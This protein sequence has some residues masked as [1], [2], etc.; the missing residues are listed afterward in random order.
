M[1]G[2]WSAAAPSNRSFQRC[3]SASI[4]PWDMSEGKKFKRMRASV[5]PPQSAKDILPCVICSTLNDP[6]KW[7]FPMSCVRTIQNTWAIIPFS[8][9]SPDPIC[10]D[11]FRKQFVFWRMKANTLK[12]KE[13]LG[14]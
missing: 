1:D 11:F 9:S 8:S 7:P 3:Q 10:C 14:L 2:M 4:S 6:S 13:D 12:D 5:R